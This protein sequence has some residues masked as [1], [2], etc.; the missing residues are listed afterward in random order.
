MAAVAEERDHS[1][2]SRKKAELMV[3]VGFGALTCCKLPGVG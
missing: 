1:V 2:R 3:S